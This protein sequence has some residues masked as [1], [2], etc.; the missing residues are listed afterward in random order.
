MH[1]L[2]Y[3][4]VSVMK[5]SQFLLE[6]MILYL[7]YSFGIVTPFSSL[8]H[9]YFL[10]TRAQLRIFH[11]SV[12]N[13]FVTDISASTGRRDFIFGVWLWHSDLYSHSPFQVYCTSTSCLIVCQLRVVHVVDNVCNLLFS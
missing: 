7:V 9:I 10:L 11:V 1:D 12:M 2:E 8:Q 3:F 4:Y 13:V 6:E 5:I